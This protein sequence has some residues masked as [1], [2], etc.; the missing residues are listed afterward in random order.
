MFN[1]FRKRHRY[2]RERNGRFAVSPLLARKR[3]KV[4]RELRAYVTEQ[5]LLRAVARAVGVE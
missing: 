2:T 1:L 3:E 5:R 4:E